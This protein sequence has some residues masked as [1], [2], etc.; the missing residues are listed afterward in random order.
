MR[1]ARRP[2]APVSPRPPPLRPRADPRSSSPPVPPPD[3]RSLPHRLRAPVPPPGP[4]KNP[5]PPPGLRRTPVSLP[6]LRRAPVSL[7][8]LQRAPVS[9][10]GLQRAPVSLPG[11]QR[12]PAQTPSRT[13]A[14]PPGL[15]TRPAPPPGLP[16]H[17][18]PSRKPGSAFR[19][20]ATS[21][22]HLRAFHTASGPPTQPPLPRAASPSTQPPGLP[23]H[24]HAF[25]SSRGAPC[26]APDRLRSGAVVVGRAA[27]AS[28][29]PGGGRLC[30]GRRM[31][32][33]R[34]RHRQLSR[35][36]PVLAGRPAPVWQEAASGRQLAAFDL[37]GP[38]AAESAELGV[39][40][41]I[42]SPRKWMKK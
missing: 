36:C 7:P 19:A 42:R 27:V 16:W 2:A 35:S 14:P 1:P 34:T 9:L 17:P 25:G 20:S 6:G 31:S 33:A 15:S 32:A 41:Q 4:S 21:R 28:L 3:R 40:E 12:A 8:G 30:P 10:P 29:V 26:T 39:Q 5:V 18:V 22:C 37:P 13:P 11:L 24:P 38:W 23:G